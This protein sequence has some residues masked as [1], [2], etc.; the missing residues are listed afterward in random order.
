[1]NNFADFSISA[2]ED[3]TAMAAHK[4]T[5]LCLFVA[6]RCPIDAPFVTDDLEYDCPFG[7]F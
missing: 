1:L 4:T 7:S 2:S 5:G 3:K 6:D